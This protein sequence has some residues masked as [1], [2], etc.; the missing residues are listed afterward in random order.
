MPSV[1]TQDYLKAI[2]VPD[3]SRGSRQFALIEAGGFYPKAGG[4]YP[5]FYGTINL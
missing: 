4:F 1:T 5:K 3:T 2:R